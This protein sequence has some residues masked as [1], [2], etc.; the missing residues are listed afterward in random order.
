M[1]PTAG[2]TQCST[3]GQ[4][5]ITLNTQ[6][7][8][9]EH[10]CSARSVRHSSNQ[11]LYSL[12]VLGHDVLVVLVAQTPYIG[13]GGGQPAVHP[14]MTRRIRLHAVVYVLIGASKQSHVEMHSD[15]PH[16]GDACGVVA[17]SGSESEEHNT[18]AG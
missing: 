10:R 5:G 11:G 14:M 9:H 1:L 6:L 8:E 4:N 16:V 2:W 17:V 7:R 12:F 18:N 15:P 3:N 13:G